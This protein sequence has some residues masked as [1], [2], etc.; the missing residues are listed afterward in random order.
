M[1]GGQPKHPRHFWN[2]L[3]FV[4]HFCGRNISE[5]VLHIFPEYDIIPV[6]DNS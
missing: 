5:I 4:G 3:T 2:L 1:L 6:I